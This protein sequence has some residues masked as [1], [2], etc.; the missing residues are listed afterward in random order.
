MAVVVMEVEKDFSCGGECIAV[1]CGVGGRGKDLPGKEPPVEFIFDDP[2]ANSCTA[3]IVM[4]RMKAY[5][6]GSDDKNVRLIMPTKHVGR[7]II[8]LQD[9]RNDA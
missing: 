8:C 5:D 2:A 6:G 4:L 3:A 7:N 1:S 9:W